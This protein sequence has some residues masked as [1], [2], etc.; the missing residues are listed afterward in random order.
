MCQEMLAFTEGPTLRAPA[1]DIVTGGSCGIN[2]G[3]D[4]GIGPEKPDR[5]CSMRKCAERQAPGNTCPKTDC[6]AEM[7]GVKFSA[8]VSRPKIRL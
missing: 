2:S 7:K 1:F 3:P 4:K 8:R 6:K 5:S